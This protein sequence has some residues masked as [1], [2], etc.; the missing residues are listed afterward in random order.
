MRFIKG[1]PPKFTIR[2]SGRGEGAAHRNGPSSTPE[3]RNS[4]FFNAYCSPAASRLLKFSRMKGASG[5][6]AGDSPASRRRYFKR[7]TIV[8][9]VSAGS[10]VGSPYISPDCPAD[11]LPFVAIQ[12]RIA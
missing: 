9:S 11:S 12:F 6:M 4:R 2:G 7:Y 5:R 8:V 3:N 10:G 1:K